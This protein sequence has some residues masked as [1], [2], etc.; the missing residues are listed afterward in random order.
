VALD[1]VAFH[2]ETVLVARVAQPGKRLL[3]ELL[4]AG[5]FAPTRRANDD[6]LNGQ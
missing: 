1:N 3:E 4:P 5:H 6:S 2:D